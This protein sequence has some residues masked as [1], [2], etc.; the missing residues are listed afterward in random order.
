MTFKE[1]DVFRFRYSEEAR[2]RAKNGLGHGDLHWCFDGQ[3]I[4][5]GQVLLDTY[6]ISCKYEGSRRV[7]FQLTAWDSVRQMSVEK[8]EADGTLT[9]VCNLNDC[10]PIDQGEFPLYAGGDAFD[11]THQHGCYKFFLRRKGAMPDAGKVRAEID[12]QLEKRR[13]EME[14]ARRRFEA[15]HKDAMRL[16]AELTEGK[17]VTRVTL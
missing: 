5:N 7:S 17:V 10:E 2:Q 16:C 6:W 14:Y 3:L 9:F 1:G 15:A 13:E 12:R 8:A 4:F 11:L